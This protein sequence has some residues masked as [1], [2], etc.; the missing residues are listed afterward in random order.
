M[1]IKPGD[2]FCW[3][4][5]KDHHAEQHTIGER[6][7]EKAHGLDLKVL[8]TAFIASSPHRHKYFEFV[9]LAHGT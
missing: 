5:C 6:S 9:R 3:S 7:F 1:G 4:A 8:A 2:E